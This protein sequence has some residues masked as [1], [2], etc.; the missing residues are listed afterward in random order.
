M[1]VTLDSIFKLVEYIEACKINQYC[2]RTLA[3]A[4]RSM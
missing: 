2:H 3:H 4:K 1:I